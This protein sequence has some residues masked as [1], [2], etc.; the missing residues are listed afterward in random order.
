VSYANVACLPTTTGARQL[1]LL[2]T[3]TAVG[4]APAGAADRLGQR[5]LHRGQHG[6]D[7]REL[8]RTLRRLDLKVSVDGAFGASTD[9]AVRRY[10]R[11]IRVPADGRV[12]PGEARGMRARAG[13]LPLGGRTLRRGDEGK[14]VRRLQQILASL[15]LTTPVDGAFGTATERAVLVLQ[16]RTAQQPADGRLT[17]TQ[18][19]TLAR[20]AA[21][22]AT[23]TGGAGLPAPAPAAAAPAATA[24]FPIAGPHHRGGAGTGFHDRGGAHQGID[25]FAGCGTPLVAPLAGTV[26][27]VAEEADAG[28]YLVLHVTATGEDLVMMHLR[29]R[30]SVRQGDRVSPGQPV[31]EV[32]QTGNADGCHLHFE[33][34][35]APGWYQGGR[36]RNPAPDLE[37]WDA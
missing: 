34:W 5:T 10:E 8:Q 18:A 12:T 33:I 9:R 19:Q 36:P 35:T 4:V 27:R 20:L 7:V 13:T 24:V 25:V 37:R 22:A 14:D 21:A 23:A 6:A 28:N 1:V 31:G 26:R 30:A 17:R 29:H 15:G 32:G 16:Q 3:V 2:L 11:R